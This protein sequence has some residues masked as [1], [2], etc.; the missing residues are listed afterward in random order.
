MAC[1]LSLK[2]SPGAKKARWARADSGE[3]K[4][5]VTSPAVDGKANSAVIEALSKG[6]G[7]SKASIKILSGHTC[8]IKRIEI[9]GDVTL[10]SVLESLGLDCI[11]EKI[12]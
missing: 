11:Q 6:I 10:E 7:V 4:C 2:V 9:A 3:I 5:Y 12:F 8:R 1:I